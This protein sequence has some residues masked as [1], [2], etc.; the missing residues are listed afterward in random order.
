MGLTIMTVRKI[1]HNALR[2]LSRRPGM[3]QLMMDYIETQN[4]ETLW[5]AIRKEA[6]E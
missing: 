5:D 1:E 4:P 2:K 3:H 6:Q